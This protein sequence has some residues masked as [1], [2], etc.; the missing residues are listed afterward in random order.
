MLVCI[1]MEPVEAEEAPPGHH[2]I[3]IEVPEADHDFQGEDSSS[4]GVNG[5]VSA[6]SASGTEAGS[7]PEDPTRASPAVSSDVQD[8]A[9]GRNKLFGRRRRRSRAVGAAGQDQAGQVLEMRQG[10][11]TGSSEVEPPVSLRAGTAST[12]ESVR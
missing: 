12:S 3:D 5:V 6:A 2:T 4:G 8:T 10:P 9:V 1:R 7:P 11:E